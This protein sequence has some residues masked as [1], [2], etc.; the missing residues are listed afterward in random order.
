MLLDDDQRA[1]FCRWLEMQINSSDGIQEQMKNT[2]MGQVAIDAFLKKERTEQMA[3]KIVLKMI[4][5]GESMSIGSGS[6]R[7]CDDGR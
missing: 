5:S 7:T 4:T 3:C 2:G 1:I 6:T